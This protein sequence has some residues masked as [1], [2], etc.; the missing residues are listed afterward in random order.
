MKGKIMIEKRCKIDIKE[1]TFISVKCK[2]CGA[3]TNIPFKSDR[4]VE[5]CSLCGAYFGSYA[6]YIKKLRDINSFDED[7]FEV[8][9]V[10]VEDGK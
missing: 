4:Y 7:K 9:L 8:S 3:E 10:S 5:T 1:A 6:S 2:T